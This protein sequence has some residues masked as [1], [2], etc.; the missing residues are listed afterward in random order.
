MGTPSFTNPED[1]QPGQE[2]GQLQVVILMS[3]YNGARYLSEQLT[4]ILNQSYSHFKLVVRDD[5]STDSTPELLSA[6]AGRDQRILVV[7]DERGNLGVS[8]SLFGMLRGKL[9][10]DFFCFCDQDD[11]WPADRLER[12]VESAIR[13]APTSNDAP[14]LWVCDFETFGAAAR[15]VLGSTILNYGR[16]RD[17]RKSLIAGN[18]LYGCVMLFNRSLAR[19]LQETPPM[20]LGFDHWVALVAA[21]TGKIQLLEFVG[22]R[23]RQHDSNVSGG[24]P[25]QTMFAKLSA[26]RKSMFS[27][28]QAIQSIRQMLVYLLESDFS[29][30]SDDS[31]QFLRVAIAAHSKSGLTLLAFQTQW[32]VWRPA[33]VSN[34]PR[35]LVLL[36][37]AL[38]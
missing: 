4:S 3:T 24:A 27:E 11:I 25:K 32:S 30:V 2:A 6:F 17:F 19:L 16:V 22:T 9:V 5:G 37:E 38:R 18:P 10:G 20:R 28:R 12:F 35:I 15:P 29:G 13:L 7:H 33:A 14:M 34:L 26:I 8:D 23:Y 1:H 36:T 21:Y 31:R